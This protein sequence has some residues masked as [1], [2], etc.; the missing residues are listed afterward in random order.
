MKV[1]NNPKPIFANSV[2][3]IDK[4]KGIAKEGY[5]RLNDQYYVRVQVFFQNN[6]KTA[7]G[8][9]QSLFK[10]DDFGTLTEC[11]PI[12]L[13]DFHNN[14]LGGQT[15]GDYFDP[16]FMEYGD[17][18]VGDVMLREEASQIVFEE[19]LS[20]DQIYTFN[21]VEDRNGV[22]DEDWKVNFN[23]SYSKLDPTERSSVDGF[24]NQCT[25][26]GK[27]NYPKLCYL[28]YHNL[29]KNIFPSG[30]MV[31]GVPLEIQL[32]DVDHIDISQGGGREIYLRMTKFSEQWL[33]RNVLWIGNP[34]YSGDFRQT[35]SLGSAGEYQVNNV[36]ANTLIQYYLDKYNL[37]LRSNAEKSEAA[38]RI[39]NV[40][41]AE[42]KNGVAAQKY[43]ADTLYAIF[44]KAWNNL[45]NY[46]NN[47][48]IN[49]IIFQGWV[50]ILHYGTLS[51]VPSMNSILDELG[52]VLD[53]IKDLKRYASTP[54]SAKFKNLFKKITGIEYNSKNMNIF[55]NKAFNTID[56]YN[57]EN[58]CKNITFEKAFGLKDP[59]NSI[60]KTLEVYQW[61]G[62]ITELVILALA[63][64]YV[65][66]LLPAEAGTIGSSAASMTIVSIAEETV[67]A[68]IN[69]ARGNKID[70][71][72]STENIVS[73]AAFG[74]VGGI[75]TKAFGKGI[76][77]YFATG[78]G[79][80]I[81]T[82]IAE[83]GSK[84]FSKGKSVQCDKL[85]SYVCKGLVGTTNFVGELVTYTGYETVLSTV[86]NVGD[87]QG[88]LINMGMDPDE[89][90]KM[91]I[92][93]ALC[94]LFGEEFVN[95]AKQLTTCKGVNGFVKMFLASKHA[96][97]IDVEREFNKHLSEM[98]IKQVQ[99]G[100]ILEKNGKSI[101][102]FK[103]PEAAFAYCNEYALILCLNK[104]IDTKCKE[105]KGNNKKSSTDKV[106]EAKDN[107][108]ISSKNKKKPGTEKKPQKQITSHAVHTEKNNIEHD[109]KVKPT[110]Q[111]FSENTTPKVILDDNN[112]VKYVLSLKPNGNIEIEIKNPG[113][114]STYR[115]M[116][117]DEV[118][119][120]LKKD[121]YIERPEEITYDSFKPNELDEVV[122]TLE[123]GSLLQEI[124]EYIEVEANEFKDELEYLIEDGKADIKEDVFKKY[125]DYFD[126]RDFQAFVIKELALKGK[127]T[128]KTLEDAKN[129]AE[130]IKNNE[131]STPERYTVTP[132]NKELLEE[133]IDFGGD[134]NLLE[135]CLTN[136][137]LIRAIARVC[138]EGEK[139]TVNDINILKDLIKNGVDIK[140]LDSKRF[141]AL[142]DIQIKTKKKFNVTEES[143]KELDTHYYKERIKKAETK[144]DLGKIKEEIEESR[145]D[146]KVAQDLLGNIETKAK[147]LNSNA[148]EAEVKPEVSSAVDHET[149]MASTQ[150]QVLK[151]IYNEILINEA[152]EPAVKEEL[153]KIV[154]D[155]DNPYYQTSEEF[156]RYLEQT[157]PQ[158]AQLL[159]QGVNGVLRFDLQQRFNDYY[160][161]F[162]T[163]KVIHFCEELSKYGAVFPSPLEKN[164]YFDG[165][166]IADKLYNEYLESLNISVGEK[167]R[168]KDIAKKYGTKVF[169][170]AMRNPAEV[171]KALDMVEAEF[172]EWNR[173]GGDNVVYPSVFDCTTAKRAYVDNE[174]AYG[175][176]RAAG[177]A[178]HVKRLIGLG[179]L[180]PVQIRHT[181]RHEMA[182]LNDLKH[183]KFVNDGVIVKNPD[184]SIDFDNCKYREE[185]LKAGILPQKI[186]YAYNNPR[187]FIAVATEGDMSR[188]S[189]EFKEML[190]KYGMPEWMFKMKNNNR[191]VQKRVREYNELENRGLTPQDIVDIYFPNKVRIF[192]SKL[193]KPKTLDFGKAIST[194]SRTCKNGQIT[195]GSN[196]CSG[197]LY[198]DKNG[199]IIC[200]KISNGEYFRYNKDGKYEKITQEEFESIKAQRDVDNTYF[201]N[202]KAAKEAK[203]K[204]QEQEEINNSLESY[205]GKD[206]EIAQKV[207]KFESESSELI[208]CEY[209]NIIGGISSTEFELIDAMM[210]LSKTSGNPLIK[211]IHNI[212]YIASEMAKRGIK[213]EQVK[214]ILNL[215]F[216]SGNYVANIYTIDQL[217]RNDFR[218]GFGVDKQVVTNIEPVDE[219]AEKISEDE[220]YKAIKSNEGDEYFDKSNNKYMYYLVD[221]KGKMVE[222]HEYEEKIE[223]YGDNSK[224]IK[225]IDKTKE[226]VASS[227]QNNVPI[228]TLVVPTRRTP[229]N[230]RTF[231]NASG[232]FA[233]KTGIYEPV[234]DSQKAFDEIFD[235]APKIA[236][237]E[238]KKVRNNIYEHYT[239][240]F[241]D[242]TQEIR[243]D[244][245]SPKGSNG[246][247][248][249]K[250]I[251]VQRGKLISRFNNFAFDGYEKAKDFD[252]LCRINA[253]C[254]TGFCE[255]FTG[256]EGIKILQRPYIK[257]GKKFDGINY[258]IKI[259][260][261]TASTPSVNADGAGKSLG[262]TRI[263][264]S[265]PTV[266]ANGNYIFQWRMFDPDFHQ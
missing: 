175:M 241:L 245:W 162:K 120:F 7:H 147:S 166:T 191:A 23:K 134:T 180:T 45:N 240:T 61:G 227:A 249:F 233:V 21:D 194:I 3:E 136:R 40:H 217:I 85:T 206:R 192:E 141:Q 219:P 130:K 152:I 39:N 53:A 234:T 6:D 121:Q 169:I 72:A 220:V 33:Q 211:N 25:E 34:S 84:L 62:M 82:K 69:V 75:Y 178:N 216:A 173:C 11:T 102:Q 159:K 160:E 156:L 138:P 149:T 259:F 235:R 112:N 139:L 32:M 172:A 265:A 258:E 179:G 125:S 12:E 248:M 171:A 199:K 89:V 96:A 35:W 168:C 13:K 77:K 177:Y 209:R 142:K 81:A 99:N 123:S 110:A 24:I 118:N 262:D 251:E 63:L 198:Y 26:N 52:N 29:H 129:Y 239:T 164:K 205:S 255:D 202:L 101:Q 260:G 225:T 90:E 38:G 137:E 230:Y 182:H 95:Q 261:G 78:K 167:W 185:F 109:K 106:G 49:D 161:S 229:R 27:I 253:R 153:L 133:H 140:L 79:Q 208:D 250:L 59:R 266:D 48:K 144:E 8:F 257:Q 127:V 15:L 143:V 196:G 218:V 5:V 43:A 9:T 68:A 186:K 4:S 105:H 128:E 181:L 155:L 264:G 122:V 92:V 228:P 184:G 154:K 174:C 16:G 91:S 51:E 97:G 67:N 46:K 189:P 94:Y 197:V 44:Y 74:V 107:K 18:S 14:Y 222:I 60:D 195:Y 111:E 238:T 28:C 20:P 221:I 187:E 210:E 146:E 103:T 244:Y 98:T 113:G 132:E 19:V 150:S 117:L 135:E 65:P 246:K 42:V 37:D 231:D 100:Y 213:L 108:S 57:L 226:N 70:F 151:E 124:Q 223:I 204:K 86:S 247:K 71:E 64:E 254:C 158:L 148:P 10:M 157:D 256:H 87:V 212:R 41:S 232:G 93:E 176:G 22:T 88:A 54:D 119:D 263:L 73:N 190:K 56:I 1:P 203:K 83:F 116:T 76:A 114:K 66:S 58:N 243:I 126:N 30:K 207:L 193:K 188:Y 183:L 237:G 145:V 165:K 214:G 252:R 2:G 224:L 47:T 163:G 55:M 242:G 50:N 31:N 36:D 80:K 215:K 236:T 17:G 131:V 115:E 104:A 201:T 200:G 170:P